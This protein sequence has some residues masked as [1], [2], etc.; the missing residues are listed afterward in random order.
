MYILCADAAQQN[1]GVNRN[2]R[3][4]KMAEMDAQELLSGLPLDFFKDDLHTNLITVS[5]ALIE[6]FAD[7][8]DI[9]GWS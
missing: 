6:T 9:L 5:P 4:K 2:W 7:N 1:M 8:T 3:M